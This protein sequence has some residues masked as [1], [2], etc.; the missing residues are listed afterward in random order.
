M[1]RPEDIPEFA[2]RIHH[3]ATRLKNLVEDIIELSKLDENSG[4][5][6]IETVDIG[7]MSREVLKIWNRRRIKRACS[8]FY[9]RRYENDPWEL[10]AAL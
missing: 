4:E 8:Y 2:G 9:R 1:V 10:P 3:E 6:P 5:L 7:E